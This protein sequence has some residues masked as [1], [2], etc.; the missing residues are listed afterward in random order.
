MRISFLNGKGGVGKTSSSLMSAEA[1]Y[2]AGYS[3]EVIDADPQGSASSW[4][5]A[6]EAGGTP[7]HFPVNIANRATLAKTAEKSTADF[8]FID[9]APND[10][11]IINA[12]A[13]AADMVI[14][15]TGTTIADMDRAIQTYQAMPTPAAILLW[16]VDPRH[17]L[18]KQSR[19]MLTDA[20]IAVFTTAIPDRQEINRAW[21]TDLSG[22]RLHG[23]DDVITELS[24]AMRAL[25]S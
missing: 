16:R 9:T 7:L 18:Y 20:D 25:T 5:E 14:I 15:P 4:A 3:A 1:A 10:P 17:Q 6:A 13:A 21:H 8:L 12:A 22:V 23:Y 11:A 19:E 24:A 2:R